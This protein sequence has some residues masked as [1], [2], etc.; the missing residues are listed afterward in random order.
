[1]PRGSTI[2]SANMHGCPIDPILL[3]GKIA[4][5]VAGVQSRLLVTHNGRALPRQTHLNGSPADILELLAFSHPGAVAYKKVGRK[6]GKFAEL[7]RYGW[8]MCMAK[9]P[10]KIHFNSPCQTF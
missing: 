4:Q 7:V 2:H 8:Y 3:W 10:P 6:T 9:G 1:M 5:G